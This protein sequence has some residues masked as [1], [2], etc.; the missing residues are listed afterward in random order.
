MLNTKKTALFLK[1][2]NTLPVAPAN[3]L[4]VAE[5]I[6]IT[7]TI[8]IEEF[9]RINGRLGSNDSYADTCDAT[10]S[11]SITHKM[12]C[13]NTAADALDTLPEYTELLKIS[14]FDVTVDTA[15][16]GQETVTFT[17]TQTP[18]VGSAV[19]YIDGYKQTMTASV[20]ADTTFNFAI[21][22]AAEISSAISAFIDNKGIATAEATPSVTLNSE[23][24]LLVACTDIMTAGGTVIKPNNVTI[25]MGAE[26]EKYYGMGL[27]EYSLNDYMIKIEA[28]FFPD[29][30]DYN[31][32]ITKLANET[33]EALVIKLGTGTAGAMVSGKSVLIECDLAKA[34]N[35]SDSDTQGKVQRTF[36]WLIQGDSTGKAISIQTG[37]FA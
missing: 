30:A 13:Q 25:S 12:R 9:K 23:P 8:T 7:P 32:A 5:P 11:Q 33:V 1:S 2:G 21:G 20:V 24:V 27:K 36:T 37:Y 18:V 26:I 17:N 16:A 10:I 31:S 19:A 35:V 22:K 29:N 4:E 15:V 28:T 34:N 6:L 14:G 3:F